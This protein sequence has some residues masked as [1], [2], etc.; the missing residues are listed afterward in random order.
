MS[1]P[2]ARLATAESL[3]ASAT[4]LY[5]E[6]LAR[7]V[8]AERDLAELRRLADAENADHQHFEGELLQRAEAAEAQTRRLQRALGEFRGWAD[9]MWPPLTMLAQQHMISIIA[10]AT[11]G[12]P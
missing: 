8:A 1:T 6:T 4:V 2:T 9:S 11:G 10:R 5:G 12:Q 3:L 7:A